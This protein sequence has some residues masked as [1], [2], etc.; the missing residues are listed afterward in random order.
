MFGAESELVREEIRQNEDRGGNAGTSELD[1][2]FGGRNGQRTG[3]GFENSASD[4]D[5]A[6]T[7]GVGLH[8]RHEAGVLSAMH[9]D[10]D[11]VPNRA[12]VHL[13]P[14]AARYPALGYENRHSTR[15]RRICGSMATRASSLA[16]NHVC[17]RG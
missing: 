7:V 3:A 14:G 16:P 4:G 13:G 15:A 12:E 11:V 2:F 6:V 1:T 9:E 5:S 8:H 17:A 10:A